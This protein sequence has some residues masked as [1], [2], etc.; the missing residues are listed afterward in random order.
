MNC[1]E[2]RNVNAGKALL[3]GGDLELSGGEP[4]DTV[5]FGD[6]TGDFGVFNGRPRPHPRPGKH[7]AS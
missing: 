2:G 1:R 6:G 5:F 7:N 3:L 4:A